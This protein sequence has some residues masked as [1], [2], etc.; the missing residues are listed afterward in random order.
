MRSL[1]VFTIMNDDLQGVGIVLLN[2][3]MGISKLHNIHWKKLENKKAKIHQFSLL[4]LII[5]P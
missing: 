5:K 4:T 3:Y 2:G 1:N